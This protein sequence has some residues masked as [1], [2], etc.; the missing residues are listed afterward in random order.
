M[1]SREP[2]M[3]ASLLMH[4]ATAVALV[5]YA[6]MLYAN[7]IPI[8]Y[9]QQTISVAD[10]DIQ[11]HTYKPQRYAGGSILLV[12]HGLGA[13]ASGYRN[14]AVPLADAHGF[15]V[16]APLFDRMRFP[17]WRYQTGGLVRDQRTTE[18][19]HVEPE[20]RWTGHLFLDIIDA[21]R[22]AEGRPNLGYSLIGHSAGGQTLTRF[23]AFVPNTARHIVI[24]NPSTYLWPSRDERFPYGFG[25]LPA[26]LTDDTVLRRYLAQPL[27]ILLG[28]ADVQRD[29]SLNVSLGAERQGEHRYAR[30]HNVF[31]AAQKLAHDRGWTFRWR[32]LDVPEIAHTARGMFGSAEAVATLSE[33]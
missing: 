29:R 2:G 4:W 31:R 23:A 7:P 1:S 22:T 25:G 8:G 20:T 21:V 13:N 28:T 3:R 14:S 24:A 12:L 30:G 27:T 16:V 19:F 32:L 5:I 10:E 17:T 15:L 18:D 9:S 11:I 33:N 6:T 26:P